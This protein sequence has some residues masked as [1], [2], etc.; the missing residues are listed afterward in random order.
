MSSTS[1]LH[2]HY[3][4]TDDQIDFYKINQYIKLKNVLDSETLTHYNHLFSTIVQE[5]TTDVASDKSSDAYSRSFIQ[6]FNLWRESEDVRSFVFSK[7]LATIATQLMNVSGVRIYHDQAL[8]KQ[9]GGNITPWHADQHY[10][11][12]ASNAAITAWIP[13]QAVPRSMG[14]LEFAAGSHTLTSGREL[15]ISDESET[16]IDKYIREGGYTTDNTSFDL[17]EVSFHSGWIFHRAGANGT[18]DTRKVMTII[19]MDEEMKL[20]QP[21]NRSQENDREQWCPGVKVGSVI[22]S[23]LNPVV[24]SEKNN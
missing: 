23:P 14:P 19:Y 24:Y 22:D 9:G 17:G 21:E 11:P 18:I 12:L 1:I 3:T 15:S 5:I 8:F 2:Q 4:L 20:K 10:W 6:C 16:K 13:L 7:R